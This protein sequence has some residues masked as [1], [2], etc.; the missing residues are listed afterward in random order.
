IVLGHVYHGDCTRPGLSLYGGIPR[1]ELQGVIRQVARPQAAIMQVRNICAGE[2]VGYNSVFIATKNMRLGTIAL[3][4]ADGY[5]RCWSGRG[6]LVAG[7][8]RLP[9]LGRVSMDMT[10]IDLTGAPEIG[11]GDWVEAEY[12][13]PH[14]AIASGLS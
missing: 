11:E 8:R 13:L 5:L 7:E 1:P 10:V 6:V 2:G 4:Y 9:V 12:S 14:A 3:G